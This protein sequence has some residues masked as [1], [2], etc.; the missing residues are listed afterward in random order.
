MSATANPSRLPTAGNSEHGL[1]TAADWNAYFQKL[2]DDNLLLDDARPFCEVLIVGGLVDRSTGHVTVETD[3]V[4]GV[5]SRFCRFYLYR[6]EIEKLSFDVISPD[7]DDPYLCHLA[8]SINRMK[9]LEARLENNLTSHKEDVQQLSDCFE[10]L[11]KLWKNRFSGRNGP[12]FPLDYLTLT[13]SSSVPLLRSKIEQALA[14]PDPEPSSEPATAPKPA[15]VDGIDN[16]SEEPPT[17]DPS[18]VPTKTWLT[19]M[20]SVYDAT[21]K[22]LAGLK[23]D[24]MLVPSDRASMRQQFIEYLDRR[25][26]ELVKVAVAEAEEDSS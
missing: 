16:T 14:A 20:S 21:T 4:K 18:A 5:L 6:L 25:L 19:N 17:N 8:N 23:E 10:A 12:R 9:R 22:V 13:F 1:P 11:Y 3:K 2:D 24:S 26:K 7:M 15:P